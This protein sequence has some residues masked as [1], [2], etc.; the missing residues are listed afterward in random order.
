MKFD[1]YYCQACKCFGGGGSVDM[2]RVQSGVYQALCP[3]CGDP[4]ERVVAVERRK[5]VKR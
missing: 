3:D 1:R 2:H 5:A 4:V